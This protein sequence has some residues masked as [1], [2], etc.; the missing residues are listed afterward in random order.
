MCCLNKKS[1]RG[2]SSTV[3]PLRNAEGNNG[4]EMAGDNEQRAQDKSE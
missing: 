3:R 4:M 1:G 2:S